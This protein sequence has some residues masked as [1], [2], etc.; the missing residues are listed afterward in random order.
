[1]ECFRDALLSEMDAWEMGKRNP[2]DLIYRIGSHFNP[3]SV[4][5]ELKSFISS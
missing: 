1:M 4:A 2:K 3:A 5:E